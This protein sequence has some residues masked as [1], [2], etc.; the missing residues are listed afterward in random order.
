MGEK[1]I[2]PA[3]R[4]ELGGAAKPVRPEEAEGIPDPPE[5]ET[6]GAL[7][8]GPSLQ[9]QRVL[10]LYFENPNA[11][12]VARAMEVSERNVRRLV[13]R[14]S[15]ILEE[16]QHDQDM[17]RLARLSA[18]AATVEEWADSILPGTLARLGELVS[19]AEEPIVLQAIRAT[20]QI[21]LR[22]SAPQTFGLISNALF[23]EAAREILHRLAVPEMDPDI[24]QNGGRRG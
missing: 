7:T 20:L 14:F 9:Q 11:A 2:E 8:K 24:D 21:A 5:P 22:P 18:R 10:R 17:E 16:W 15:R 6:E 4:D 1:A 13:G 19:G 23:E 3:R 12:A